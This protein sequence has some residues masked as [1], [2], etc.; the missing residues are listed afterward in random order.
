MHSYDIRDVWMALKLSK[1]N[2]FILTALVLVLPFILAYLFDYHDAIELYNRVPILFEQGR[3]SAIFEI[4]GVIVGIVL[5]GIVFIQSIIIYLVN[6]KYVIDLETGLITF[7][8]SDMENS[9]FAIILL[10]PYWNLMRRMSV[11]A[12]EIENIYIDTKRWSTKVNAVK[13]SHKSITTRHVKYTINVVGT[14][15]SANF[16]FLERQKRDEVRNAIQQCVKQHTG[17]N[18]DRKIAEFN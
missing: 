14:F 4:E 9:I 12:S 7:P 6:R 8:R 18:V 17:K 3:Y 13:G 5:I 10:F 11:Q 2:F 16:Q 1:N 15:G